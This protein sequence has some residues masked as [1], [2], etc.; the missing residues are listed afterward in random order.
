[1]TA[2]RSTRARG[3]SNPA[4]ATRVRAILALRG[5]SAKSYSCSRLKKRSPSLVVVA[6][7]LTPR[8]TSA[9]AA[10]TTS[11]F[12]AG[13][14]PKGGRR[15]HFLVPAAAAAVASG[16]G[17]GGGGE[18]EK[19]KGKG[20]EDDAR[21]E[22]E[23]TKNN[24]SSSSSS[25]SSSSSSPLYPHLNLDFK[26]KL[27]AAELAWCVSAS[28]AAVLLYAVAVAKV[29]LQKFVA[30]N[31]RQRA[32]STFSL[33]LVFVVNLLVTRWMARE[34]QEQARLVSPAEAADP[35]SL[36]ADVEGL[37]VHYKLRRPEPGVEDIVK[38]MGAVVRVNK[39]ASATP[40][41]AA[42]AAAAS[43]G[44]VVSCVHGFG[45]NTYSWERA[46]LQPLAT[47]L[48][49]TVVAHDTPGFGEAD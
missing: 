20:D 6:A 16:D 13:S 31:A 26:P 14:A 18:K 39:P 29:N 15:G 32:F 17:E 44:T 5:G 21:D 48:G 46:T 33:G 12:G 34:A 35:D 27:T 7:G 43:P 42:A 37:S 40:S 8:T 47:A 38:K 9:A 41:A 30:M 19:E 11:G 3:P 2:G 45:A 49:A 4:P 10:A 24:V 1:M 25:P 36:F 23:N 22:G 28:T